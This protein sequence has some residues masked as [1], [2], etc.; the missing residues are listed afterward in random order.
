MRLPPPLTLL[1]LA[2]AAALVWTV[3][4]R[5]S[6]LEVASVAPKAQA[7]PAPESEAE[8]PRVERY[9]RR[10]RPDVFYNAITERPLFSSTR[11]P[12]GFAAPEAEEE[13]AAVE[14]VE[15]VDN[16]RIA[17]S[18]TLK[19]VMFADDHKSALISIDG[20][21]ADWVDDGVLIDD[22]RLSIV[23]PSQV[24]LSLENQTLSF[25]L[26]QNQ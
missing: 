10:S 7:A 3:Y 18:L 5:S 12:I 19:G 9:K 25:G 23:S 16:Q 21:Q 13:V 4:E 24:E 17:P 15:E 2:A 8:A 1:L 6:E 14:P 26:Y 22:W 11:R 20:E